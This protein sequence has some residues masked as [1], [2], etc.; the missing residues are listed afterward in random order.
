MQSYKYAA[1]AAARATT[2]IKNETILECYRTA[3]CY[4][5]LCVSVN[6]HN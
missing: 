3:N 6:E 5:G 1:A 4:Y 2:A